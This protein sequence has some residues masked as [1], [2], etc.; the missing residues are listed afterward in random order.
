MLSVIIPF[1]NR[2]SLT[3]RAIRSL[4]PWAQHQ[5]IRQIIVVNDAS[6]DGISEVKE[7]LRKVSKEVG[8][9]SK[10]LN[11]SI[12]LGASG[13]KNFGAFNSDSE[14]I[15]FL[16]SDDELIEVTAN[17][18]V[19]FKEF[20]MTHD[21]VFVRC[22]EFESNLV[23]GEKAT[24]DTVNIN[25]YINGELDFECLPVMRRDVFLA[26]PYSKSLRGCEGLSYLK[27]LS[28][29]YKA[30]YYATPMR[31]YHSEAD[32]RISSPENLARRSKFLLYY[33]FLTMRYVR[34]MKANVL[35]KKIMKIFV[36]AIAPKF[37]LKIMY[38]KNDFK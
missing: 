38:A 2:T 30:S 8:A 13:A 15:L 27:I 26:Y 36:Y 33:H 35:L 14:Y 28:S 24:N 23:I 31:M 12:N 22:R 17:E 11:T 32:G 29:G 9:D 6:S 10:F 37:L 7:V 5:V 25:K 3:C 16:D 1:Y 4:I 18:M 20:I 19:L 21:L 34:H